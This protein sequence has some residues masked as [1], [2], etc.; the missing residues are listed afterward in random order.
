[1]W[2]RRLASAFA[3]CYQLAMALFAFWKSTAEDRRPTSVIH[4][5][6]TLAAHVDPALNLRHT[7]DTAGGRWHLAAF[8]T[9][10]HFLAPEAQIDCHPN[11]GTCVIHGVMW[12]LDVPDPKPLDA[13]AVSAMLSSPGEHFKD[14]LIAGE[15]AVA[16]LYPCGTLTAF[17]DPAGLHQ[18]F[19]QSKRQDMLANRASF[20]SVLAND[21]DIGTEASLWIATIGYRVGAGTAWRNVRQLAANEIWSGGTSWEQ[22]PAIGGAAGP[23]GYANGGD[24]LLSQ[25]LDQAISAVRLATADDDSIDLPITGG[26][27]SRAVLAICLGAGLRHRLRLFTRGFADH[28]DVLAGRAIA[29]A[30]R[31][32]HRRVP[33]LGS[34][35]PPDWPLELFHT[36]MA[37]LAFQTDGNMGGWDLITGTTTGDE[38]LLTG[39]L[40][41]LLKAYAK[42]PTSSPIDPI[43]LVRLQAPFDPLN[44]VRD[45]ARKRMAGTLAD[46]FLLERSRYALE[47]DLPD[48]FYLRNRVPNWLGGVRGVKSLER[49]PILPLGVPALMKLA[50]LMTPAERRKELA[51]YELVSRAAPELLA[52]PFAHQRWSETLPG[53]PQ[54]L[55]ILCDPDRPLFGNWQYSINTRPELRAHIVNLFSRSD[56]ELWDS[57]DRTA[58]LDRLAHHKISYF[59]G[60]SLLGLTV[61]VYHALGLML[62][63]RLADPKTRLRAPV[64]RPSLVVP[65]PS[66]VSARALEN[67]ATDGEDK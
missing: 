31:L 51:H 49:Q 22:P 2:K 66:I 43:E 11:R 15:Y 29:E 1:M 48:L 8:A 34:D 4:D 7:I 46:Q 35:I 39:H 47:E 42:R 67:V 61:T 52:P 21:K 56:L 41:E 65:H 57:I 59:D 14:D 3:A 38:T 40:G 23:R 50:F 60:I 62:T 17:G 28:P 55:P 12:R 53:A 54:T 64:C 27:D 32:P 26:K 63:E 6:L 58:L 10:T 30:A 36:N 45:Q 37:R 44:I 24:Q 33:P 18:I 5:G 19:C 9:Q 25:G 20:L 13:A 16:K